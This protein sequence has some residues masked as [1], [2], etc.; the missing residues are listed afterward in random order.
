M[1]RVDG[2]A[3]VVLALPGKQ[4]S[5]AL[6]VRVVQLEGAVE[7]FLQDHVAGPALQIRPIL[8]EAVDDEWPLSL[9]EQLACHLPQ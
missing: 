3:H 7:I 8:G 6:I 9:L 5:Q 2:V 1:R 4:L